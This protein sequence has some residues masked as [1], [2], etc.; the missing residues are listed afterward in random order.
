QAEDGIRDFHVTGVQTC[1]LPIY[2]PEARLSVV[3]ISDEDDQS[4]RPTSFYASF[5]Q[6]LK[7]PGREEDVSVN[8]VVGKDCGL[9]AEEGT[10]YQEV[11]EATGGMIDE[12]K[13][14][15][16]GTSE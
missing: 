9:M 13:S 15:V 2:R 6:G 7:G 16:K 12:R 14:V 1:A 8:V 4:D 10:R 11:A 3:I 5:F